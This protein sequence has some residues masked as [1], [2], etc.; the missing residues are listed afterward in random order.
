MPRTKQHTYTTETVKVNELDV[1][2]RVQREELKK[3]KVEGIVRDYNPDAVGVIHVSRRRTEN[4]ALVGLYVI[5]GWHRMEAT[6]IVT[7][8]TGELPAH[9]YEG[10]TV[11]EEAQMFLDL[12]NSTQISAMDKHKVR[13][14]G[15]DPQALRIEENVRKYGWHVN[16][17]PGDSNVNAVLKLYQLD[18]LSQALEVEPDLVSATFL[19]ITR[20]WGT[21]RHGA[22]AVILEGI[23]ALLVE[24]GSRINFDRL[25]ERLRDYKG[26]PRA[27]H[28]EA[29]NFATT[30]K[31]KVA[32]A[33]AFLITNWY[34][35]GLGGNSKAALPTWTRRTLPNGKK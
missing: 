13:V 10:L 33:V 4:G 34:N 24:H 11:A 35:K 28:T 30:T 18:E 29:A 32:M 22:Q 20:A 15:G 16:L 25:I 2:R 7:D 12:N 19:V 27:L 5:D 14:T 3:H 23:A 31:G 26:G 17:T 21:D 9:V 6:R 8:N 1:D